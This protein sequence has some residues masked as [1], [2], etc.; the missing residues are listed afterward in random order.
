MIFRSLIKNNIMR[1]ILI[2]L[3]AFFAITTANAQEADYQIIDEII[4]VVGDE[5]IMHSS[6]VAQKGQAL[7]SGFPNNEELDCSL[8]ENLLYEKLLLHQAKLDSVE[9][10]E[11][12]IQGELD[13][14]IAVFSERLG[15]EDKLA[16]FYEKSIAEIKREFYQVIKDQMIIQTMQG[17][18]TSEVNLTPADITDFYEG[19]N[20]DSLPYINSQVEVS[21]ILIKPVPSEQEI[22]KVT[23]RLNEFRRDV[24][25]GD[26]DF[27]TM[28]VLYSED[29][30]SAAKG[31]ELGKVGKGVM[32]PEFEAIAYNLG[33]GEISQVFKTD[34]GY[35]IMQMIERDGE[36]YNARHI[37]MIPKIA[38][39]DLNTSK[40]RL[41]EIK[42]ML[43][44]DTI[45]FAKAALEYSEDEGTKHNNGLM[46]NPATG[47]TRFETSEVDPQLFFVIDKLEVGE[48]SDPVL[49]KSQTG[50]E[51][52]RI[53][54]LRYR[55][56]P[57]Q[58]NLKDDYQ[59]IKQMAENEASQ[60]VIDEWIKERVVSTYVWVHD[61]HKDCTFDNDWIHENN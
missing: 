56:E 23:D 30:G 20:K 18:I 29:P 52:Y 19:L 28:A 34:F 38:Q 16:E 57:H 8:M 21:Q 47:S 2:A 42:S 61:K 35:H 6:F 58:A 39:A 37:L 5:I 9:V 25:S 31:G 17:Q 44:T 45:S 1:K 40:E 48:V 26:K 41:M 59:L 7:S 22:K 12:Q 49:I 24:L 43:D 55:S 46:I 60:K 13:R 3:V 50:Q 27:T 33:E 53:V 54:R 15:G 11:A 4:G 14:R 32:V 10:S 36:R 51:A